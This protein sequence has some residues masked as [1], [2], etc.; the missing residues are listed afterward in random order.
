[1]KRFVLFLARRG[2]TRER[3]PLSPKE[4]ARL[5]LRAAYEDYLR[6][7]RGL[8][9]RTITDSWRFAGQFLDFR[10]PEE[11]DDLGNISA[12]DIARFLHARVIQRAPR[13]KTVPSHL[14]NFFRYLFKAGKTATNLGN[15]V[16]RV[17]QRFGVR[18]PRH[19][20]LEQVDMILDAVRN[21]A[22]SS[23][24]NYAMVLL[25]A[26]LALRPQEVVAM[27][28]EDIDWRSGEI[29]IRGKGDRHDRLP[30]LPE[31]GK[32]LA[33][34]IK[35]ERLT[36]SRSL[37]VISRPPHR[38]F[39]DAQ[40][41]NH[42]LCKAYDKTGLKPPAPYVGAQI[43]RHSL[44]TNLVRNG[45]SLEEISDTLRHRSR[46]TTLI[47]ARLDVEGLRSIA[48]PWPTSGGAA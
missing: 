9:E 4:A 15:A 45:A 47:Y 18:L 21:T 23:L 22:P 7:Q 5:E 28:I 34:Y 26:R 46:A 27:Q 39:K 13:D 42:I 29:L 11:A 25:M 12:A 44:A 36:T 41:L 14:R 37:F 1:M 8:S 16:P 35:L 24:R 38:P 3:P 19:L 31:V 2:V 33:D 32:A 10:F 20:S 6:R 40:V 30:L 17:A 43:L 48:Q